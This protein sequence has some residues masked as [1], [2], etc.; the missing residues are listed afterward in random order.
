M[1]I[2]KKTATLYR[3]MAV[4]ILL[5]A[6]INTIQA[7]QNEKTTKAEVQ[8]QTNNVQV[9]KPAN[10]SN[11]TLPKVTGYIYENYKGITNPEEAKK[12]WIKDNPETYRKVVH[13]T[14]T[15]K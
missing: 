6:C 7:K 2:M 9:V 12:A 4:A 5:V 13:P 15:S 8:K 3:L 14:A 11:H 1:K 10:Q